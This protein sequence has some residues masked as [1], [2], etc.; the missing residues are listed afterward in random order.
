[1]S[2]QL[3]TCFQLLFFSSKI[4]WHRSFIKHSTPA[5][6]I[7]NISLREAHEQALPELPGIPGDGEEELARGLR[8]AEDIVF[9]IPSMKHSPH[10]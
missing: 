4:V 5:W 6:L 3:F 10:V 8:E 9:E 2:N 7:R 1:M